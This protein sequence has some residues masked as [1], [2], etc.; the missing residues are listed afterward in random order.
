MAK[1]KIKRLNKEYYV[2]DEYGHDDSVMVK[3]VNELI[4]VI[5]HQQEIINSFEL[6]IR[7]MNGGSDGK[8]RTSKN[9]TKR[10]NRK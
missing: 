7:D 10:S 9:G 4:T 8:S 5:N 2:T 6:M 1:R 3:K